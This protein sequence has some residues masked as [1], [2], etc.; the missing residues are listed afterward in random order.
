MGE[1]QRMNPSLQEMFD[2]LLQHGGVYL[3]SK[4]WQAL[5][6]KNVQQ[7]EVSGIGNIKR[8]VAQNYFTWVVGFGHDQ[9]RFLASQMGWRDWLHILWE[10]TPYDRSSGLTRKRF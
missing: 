8:T 2:C 5:N 9:F 3:P 10:L 4:F 1:R 6:D 7:L